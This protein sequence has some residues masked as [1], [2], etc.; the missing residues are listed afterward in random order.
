MGSPGVKVDIAEIPEISAQDWERVLKST[1]G[2]PSRT[3][4]ILT[5]LHEVMSE[6]KPTSVYILE[7]YQAYL[8]L[9]RQIAPHN[10]DQQFI[11]ALLRLAIEEA[12]NYANNWND[13][14]AMDRMVDEIISGVQ[15]DDFADYNAVQDFAYSVAK[16]T[17]DAVTGTLVSHLPDFNIAR[18][19]GKYTYEFLGGPYGRV[20]FSYWE[21]GAPADTQRWPIQ[22]RPI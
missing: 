7:F 6:R 20:K 19:A 22:P 17:Q 16:W 14:T 9:F 11:D 10:P 18:Y 21:K 3:R 12:M 2:S 4:D 15:R 8:F 1:K 13:S 5:Q